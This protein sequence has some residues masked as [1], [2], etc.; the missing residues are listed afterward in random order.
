[1]NTKN[2]TETETRESSIPKFKRSTKVNVWLFLA[3][4]TYLVTLYTLRDHPEWDPQ[5]RVGLTLLPLLPGLVYLRRLWGTFKEMDELQRRIQL[6]AWAFALG[7]TVLVSTTMN[8]LNANGI[9]FKDYPHG[10]EMGGAYI[11]VFFFW[12]LGVAQATARYR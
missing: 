2:S 10:L 5:F 3:T 1:M 9:G 12:C 8:I 4:A 7:G 11:S 6:E